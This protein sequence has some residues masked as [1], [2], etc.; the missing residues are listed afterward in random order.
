MRSVLLMRL[1]ECN[2]S[3]LFPDNRRIWLRMKNVGNY[4]FVILL[5]LMGKDSGCSGKAVTLVVPASD[6]VTA[7]FDPQASRVCPTLDFASCKCRS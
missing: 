1:F 2:C 5:A 3:C 7:P 6:G 4:F